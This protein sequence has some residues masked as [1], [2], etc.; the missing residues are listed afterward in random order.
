MWQV[1]DVGMETADGALLSFMFPSFL[2]ARSGWG[3]G[4]AV[5]NTWAPPDVGVRAAVIPGDRTG[6]VVVNHGVGRSSSPDIREKR[7]IQR[8]RCHEAF[9]F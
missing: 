9:T 4:W 5:S 6:A 1:A 8:S 2:L 3:G 7:Y